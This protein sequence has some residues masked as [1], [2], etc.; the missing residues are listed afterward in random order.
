MSFWSQLPG[1]LFAVA[2]W[3]ASSFALDA[4]FDRFANFRQTYGVLG[5]VIALLTWFYATAVALLLG[6]ELNAEIARVKRGE[7]E[8]PIESL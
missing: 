4:Y 7:A 5:A 2:V 8:P 1:S 6:A 3:I